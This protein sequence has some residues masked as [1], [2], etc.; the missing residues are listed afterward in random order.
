MFD[1]CGN[2]LVP[3]QVEDDQSQIVL[4]SGIWVELGL[5]SVKDRGV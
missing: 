1:R 5:R 2:T 4:V 3:S